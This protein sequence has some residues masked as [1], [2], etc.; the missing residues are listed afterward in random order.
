MHPCLWWRSLTL[1][2]CPTLREAFHYHFAESA[3]HPSPQPL[4]RARLSESSGTSPNLVRV[5]QALSDPRWHM[6]GLNVREGFSCHIFLIH[7]KYHMSK[8][9]NIYNKNPLSAMESWFGKRGY[10]LHK[11]G[12]ASTMDGKNSCLLRRPIEHQSGFIIG[13]LVYQC[14]SFPKMMQNKMNIRSNTQHVL[15]PGSP[16][17]RKNI[18]VYSQ[19]QFAKQKYKCQHCF[20]H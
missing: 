10:I 18:C 14:I 15:K 17:R 6:P 12:I 20:S 8:H 5:D 16:I 7:L 19:K 4:Q 9:L 13:C 3:N 2:P 1:T 11:L